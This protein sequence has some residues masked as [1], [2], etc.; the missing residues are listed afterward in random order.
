MET[1]LS[2]LE[3]VLVTGCAGFI[4][5]N[6]T[7]SLLDAGYRV[8]GFDN[9]NDYYSPVRKQ[10]NLTEIRKETTHPERF[11]FLEGDLRDRDRIRQLFQERIDRIVHLAAMAGVRN[12]IEDPALYIDVNLN[13]TL[14]LLDAARDHKVRNFV[15]GSTSSVY[16]ATRT[17]PFVETDPCDRPLS[18]YPAT[19]RAA[20]M[21]GYSYHHLYG[22]NF[23]VLRFFTVYGP[24]GRPDMMA[25]RVLDNLYFGRKTPLYRGGDMHRDWTS[26]SDIVAG[27]LS[28]TG[29]ELG[30]TIINL[31]RGEPI[32]VSDFV[33]VMEKRAGKKASLD[34]APMM[35]ADMPC[36]YAD[37][38]RAREL[39]GYEPKVGIQ[40]GV[41]RFHDWY[42][43]AV[44]EDRAL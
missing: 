40:E 14:Y 37:I 1:P 23:T 24:R 25:H 43:V 34:N 33:K 17:I 32:L 29:R 27:V 10:A 30:Y 22:L 4:G 11:R 28:A 19:K 41:E 12:S 6:A 36:T 3:T 7:V 5:S 21:L 39:L 9:L 42:R 26:V 38:T 2:E 18:P 8:V 20:E 13:A 15:F 44:L 35:D 16:G 31:G